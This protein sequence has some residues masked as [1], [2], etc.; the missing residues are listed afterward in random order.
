MPEFIQLRYKIIKKNLKTTV[1]LILTF[2]IG[3]IAGFILYRKCKE[4]NVVYMNA[5]AYYIKAISPNGNVFI[6]SLNYFFTSALFT[7]LFFGLSFSVYTL[8]AGYAVLLVRGIV[9]GGAGTVM[10]TVYKLDGLVVFIFLILIQSILLSVVLSVLLVCNLNI[11]DDKCKVKTDTINFKIET[12][13][14]IL[15]A[16]LLISIYG[17]I[18]LMIVIRPLYAIF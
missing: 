9:I 16:C 3:I 1:T 11:N 8:P 13:G 7:V 10:F 14:L 5:I 4:S 17:L 2:I 12:A 15:F 6:V 18:V